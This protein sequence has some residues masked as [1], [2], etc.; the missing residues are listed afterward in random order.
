MKLTTPVPRC[1]YCEDYA[2]PNVCFTADNF[3]CNKLRDAQKA[4]FQAWI[5]Q[6]AKKKKSKLLILEI[7]C[8]RHRDSIGIEKK[9]DGTLRTLSR[10]I[11]LPPCFNAESVQIVKVT[12]D[13]E[14][15]AGPGEMVFYETGLQF[16]DGRHEF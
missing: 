10:E 8:G 12:L 16:F 7:G 4:R 15:A 1:I 6:V 14:L 5:S 9:P 13:R 3:F 2:R 11:S